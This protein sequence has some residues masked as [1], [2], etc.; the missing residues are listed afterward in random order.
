MS[1]TIQK[2]DDVIRTGGLLSPVFAL[3]M[4]WLY[5]YRII[6]RPFKRRR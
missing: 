4:H 2:D 5:G 1:W 3:L 6:D